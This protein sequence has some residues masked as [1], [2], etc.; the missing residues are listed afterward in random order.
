MNEDEK[1]LLNEKAESGDY[2]AARTL[3]NYYR[4][5]EQTITDN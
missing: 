3:G 2:D 5:L 4:Q 1:R